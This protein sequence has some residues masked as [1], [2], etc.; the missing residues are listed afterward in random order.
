M[1]RSNRYPLQPLSTVIEGFEAG[2]SV[3]A[4]DRP[5]EGSEHG[6]LKV[7]AVGLGRFNP[8]EQ[9]AVLPKELTRLGPSIRDGD[10]LVTRANTIDLVGAAAVVDRDYPNLHLSDKT[11]RVVPRETGRWTKA[12]LPFV[13]NS[14]WIRVAMKKIATGSSGS[15]KNVAQGAFLAI[16]VPMPPEAERN[17]IALTLRLFD[18]ERFAAERLVRLQRRRKH[19]LMQR[20]LT[21]GNRLPTY[22]DRAWNEYHLGEL[23]TERVESGRDDLPLL[24]ITAD[25]GVVSREDVDRKD[26]SAADKS[27]YLRVVPGDIG[28]NTMRMWQGVSAL[29]A[30]EGIVS[31]AY[32]ICIPGPEVDGRF[33]SYL[34]KLPA[35]VHLFRRFSQGLVDDTL[36]LKFHHFAQIRLRFPPIE[37]QR[38]IADLLV[39]LD[40]QIGLLERQRQLFELERRAITERLLSGDLRV[41]PKGATE[42]VPA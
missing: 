40:Q 11:W 23:F 1:R 13:L 16:E 14:S 22:A 30:L 36:N 37:E 27:T 25:R 7:S 12:W 17:A 9:K 6:V 10:I 8:A 2:V 4:E 42:A 5:A 15:M 31:P 24:S 21:G 28:Y 33:A 39:A 38:A 20:L 3:N 26:T 35:V 18:R 34:F 29:S 32:T 41:S 19:G